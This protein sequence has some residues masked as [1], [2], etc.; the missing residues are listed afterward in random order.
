MA[1]TNQNL[2]W[3]DINDLAQV[4]ALFSAAIRRAS[5][6]QLLDYIRQRKSPEEIRADNEEEQKD[7]EE[8]DRGEYR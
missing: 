4:D 8:E 5:P 3:V 6:Q 2:V 1:A 7:Q